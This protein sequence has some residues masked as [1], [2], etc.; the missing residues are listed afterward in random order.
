MNDISNI[1]LKSGINSLIYESEDA[2]K[3]SLINCLS[4]KLNEAMRSV[5]ESVSSE[6]LISKE[7][8]PINEDITNLINFFENYNSQT[9]NKLNLKNNTS[10]NILEHQV[11]NLKIL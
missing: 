10:I 11:E 8:T 9:N 3:K 7:V 4:F 6:L 1:V 2:F 5:H